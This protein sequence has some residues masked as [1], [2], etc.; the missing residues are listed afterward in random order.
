MIELHE[1]VASM[2]ADRTEQIYFEMLAMLRTIAVE[3]EKTSAESLARIDYEYPTIAGLLDQMLEFKH[4]GPRLLPIKLYLRFS[5]Y[6][7]IRDLWEQKREWGLKLEAFANLL[8]PDEHSALLNNIGTTFRKDGDSPKALD[9]YL[10]SIVARDTDADDLDLA[11]T[12]SN[13]AVAYWETGDIDTALPYAHRGLEME[14]KLGHRSMEAMSLVNIAG[15]LYERG[16]YQEAL[17]L[18]QQALDI[19]KETGN[20]YLIAEYTGQLAIHLLANLKLDE[21]LIANE[22]AIGL[23]QDINDEVGLAR[24]LFHYAMLKNVFR[25]HEAAQ[26]L[27]A[28]SLELMHRL[29]M[30]E[31]DL[32]RD[33]LDKLNEQTNQA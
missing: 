10:R 22:E 32:V 23:L 4:P 29:R 12:Y 16:E 20:V 14:R 24:T 30:P 17:P 31:A 13:I 25:E 2:F 5:W 33:W 15:M 18:V 3:P 9:Y 21:A 8:L 6:L 11:Y 1:S 28:E 27:A 7:N 26:A 19:A